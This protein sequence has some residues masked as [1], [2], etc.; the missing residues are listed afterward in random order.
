MLRKILVRIA[1]VAGLAGV[2][3]AALAAQ[4]LVVIDAKGA[5]DAFKPGTQLNADA[6]VTLKAGAKLSL[7]SESG[8]MVVL[9]GPYE[10]K[11]DKA[12]KP[13]SGDAGPSV[14][15]KISKLVAGQSKTIATGA[16]RAL[17][18]D[19]PVPPHP[20]FLSVMAAGERCALSGSPALW[21]ADKS[22]EQTLTLTLGAGQ[23]TTLKW[24]AGK[25][26]ILLPKLFIADGANI[27]ADLDGVAFVLHMNLRPA[28][29]RKLVPLFGWMAEKNC[30]SQAAALLNVLR[31]EAKVR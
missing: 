30:T 2:P 17:T 18:E 12:A 13:A 19:G 31:G 15:A 29:V 14:M 1:V 26:R 6:T 7:L 28:K 5:G 22:K 4:V 10:G 3:G 27:T 20:A 16:S 25:D 9:T 8:R 23:S 21:R 24:A 11:A